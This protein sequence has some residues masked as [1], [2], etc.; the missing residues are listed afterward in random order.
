MG[1]DMIRDAFPRSGG[2]GG[3]GLM[4]LLGRR[5]RVSRVEASVHVKEQSF[6]PGARRETR[7]FLRLEQQ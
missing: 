4:E 2:I 6:I 7:S 5:E 3:S 1:A